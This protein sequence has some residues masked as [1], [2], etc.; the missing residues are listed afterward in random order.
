VQVLGQFAK[1]L[2]DGA[3]RQPSNRLGL[4]Q[5]RK[6]SSQR[7]S[8]PA[9]A[10]NNPHP[11]R[12]SLLSVTPERANSPIACSVWASKIAL[13]TD[14]IR[15]RFME[16]VFELAPQNVQPPDPKPGPV[17]AFSLPTDR[18]WLVVQ[19]TDYR[20]P[21]MGEFEDQYR[22]ALT[23]AMASMKQWAVSV[24]WFNYDNIVKRTGFK[25]MDR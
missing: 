7:P 2:A 12:C 22:P 24:D 4:D 8:G 11:L 6:S 5:V 20:P 25:P 15:Q 3:I 17:K 10:R 14:A 16:Q 9:G 1:Y 18:A 21:P 23:E 13:Q 19:R